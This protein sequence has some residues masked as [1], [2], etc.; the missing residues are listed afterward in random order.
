MSRL[1]AAP[2]RRAC[3][4]E[5]GVAFWIPGDLETWRAAAPAGQDAGLPDFRATATYADRT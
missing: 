2:S 4:G 1:D 3:D 5:E